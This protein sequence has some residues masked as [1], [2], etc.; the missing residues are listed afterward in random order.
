MSR[1]KVRKARPSE[2][3]RM[4]IKSNLRGY[5]TWISEKTRRRGYRAEE[6]EKKLLKH[7][8]NCEQAEAVQYQ[9]WERYL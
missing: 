7:G 4:R 9:V 1:C 5:W 3:R 8:I 6:S 2:A